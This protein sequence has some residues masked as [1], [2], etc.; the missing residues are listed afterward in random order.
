MLGFSLDIW[1]YLT[2]AV[3]LALVGAFL[4]VAVFILGLPGRIA[5]ARKH[6]DADAI[7]TMGWLGFLAVVPWMQAFMWAFKPT[8]VVDIRYFPKQEQQNIDEG[9]ARLKGKAI[10]AN[11]VESDEETFTAENKEHSVARAS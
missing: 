5:I 1:D 3:I 8:D 10:R 4:V 9:I 6:P 2:F 7:N 11:K